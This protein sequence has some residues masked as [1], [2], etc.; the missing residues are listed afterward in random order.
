MTKATTVKSLA[1][2]TA[3]ALAA[4]FSSGASA[5]DVTKAGE[6][7]SAV[8]RS[9]RISKDNAKKLVN[10]L[11]RREYGGEGYE[12]RHIRKEGDAWRIRIKDRLRTVATAYVDRKT[13]NIH[14]E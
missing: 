3:I 11:L 5:H 8:P 2:A 14:I 9:D 7:I 13:G 12:A 10:E 6:D 1:V 4:S